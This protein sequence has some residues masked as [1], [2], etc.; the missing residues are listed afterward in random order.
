M[1]RDETLRDVLGFLV[2]TAVVYL[3]FVQTTRG[4]IT[5]ETL[6]A[7]IPLL[8][9]AGV[10]VGGGGVFAKLLTSWLRA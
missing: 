5:G 4:T 1:V 8:L 6:L 3:I 7:T 10:F 2:G 9:L